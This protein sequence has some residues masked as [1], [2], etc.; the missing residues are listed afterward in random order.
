MSAAAPAPPPDLLIVGG[1]PAGLAA[2]IGARLAG[3]SAVVLDRA[4]PPIDKA[5]GEGLM[6]DGVA[7]LRRLGVEPAHLGGHP[8]RGIR[9]LD[10]SAGAEAAGEFPGGAAGLGLRRTRLHAAL[11]RRAEE[12]GVELRWGTAV[13]G[14]VEVGG[15][16]AAATAAGTVTGRVL[17]AADGLRSRLR[18]AAGL[19]A[20]PARRRRF[21]V[22]RHFRLAPW[23]DEVEVWWA[24]GREAYVT[25]A[26]D[27]EVGVAILWSPDRSPDRHPSRG[28]F[29]EQLAAFPR[30]AARL[31]GAE[32]ASK[33][34]GAGPFHQRVRAVRRGNL[35]LLGDAAGYLDALTGEG[36]A[37]AF[38]QA[39]AL[40]EAVAGG[41]LDR[42][43]RAHRRLHRLPDAMTALLLAVERHPRLRRRMVRAL[44]AEPA[45]FSRLLGVHA[46]SLPLSEFGMRGAVRLAWELAR[47]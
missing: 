35:V 13:E 15:R 6:P 17:V 9:Y 23:S 22:R 37:L 21:G 34:R 38:H 29:D 14:L 11:V 8:F 26:G 43:A 25:P 7:A 30:L 2:A 45:L 24:D 10:D 4:R 46:R 18:R 36:L 5:C 28:G 16:F 12:V 20:A 3:L 39:A 19:A 41:D 32:A 33:D 40:V 42:Y 27:G 44:A 47:A 1:G 31:A